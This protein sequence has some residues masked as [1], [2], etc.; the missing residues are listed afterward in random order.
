LV[1]P[2]CGSERNRP[3]GRPLKKLLRAVF[4]GQ[5]YRCRDCMHRWRPRGRSRRALRR[6]LLVAGLLL[7]AL[8]VLYVCLA[9]LELVP[10]GV[11]YLRTEKFFTGKSGKEYTI[12]EAIDKQIEKSKKSQ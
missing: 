12:G 7:L 4:G 2:N 5:V 1:C 9:L 8:G 3:S 10:E 11:N 6:K